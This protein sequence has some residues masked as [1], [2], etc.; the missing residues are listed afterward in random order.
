MWDRPPNRSRD[1]ERLRTSTIRKVLAAFAC[2]LANGSEDRQPLGSGKD[3]PV[4]FTTRAGDNFRWP[5]VEVKID[6]FHNRPYRVPNADAAKRWKAEAAQLNSDLLAIRS[7][8]EPLKA[9]LKQTRRSR[10]PCKI[11]GTFNNS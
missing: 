5:T 7:E 10:Q 3:Q 9:L 11:V 8:R 1:Q 2:H 4:G 6:R